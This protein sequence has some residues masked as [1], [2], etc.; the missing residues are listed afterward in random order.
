MLQAI[1]GRLEKPFGAK[2]YRIRKHLLT[3]W[4]TKPAIR[5]V[6]RGI[7]EVADLFLNSGKFMLL[8]VILVALAN[9][10]DVSGPRI[11]V[12]VCALTIWLVL[13]N[14]GLAIEATTWYMTVRR[15]AGPYFL[16]GI[17]QK[18]TPR[19]RSSGRELIVFVALVSF[20]VLNLAVLVSTV[21]APRYGG[22]VTNRA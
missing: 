17:G 1:T 15:Y 6:Q 12:L 11:N 2:S 8:C 18:P 9:A 3:P 5:I 14:I 19:P 21:P 22:F 4:S 13:Y 16:L 20:A 10:T 7:C